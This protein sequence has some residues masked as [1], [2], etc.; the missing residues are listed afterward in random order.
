ML[1]YRND[2]KLRVLDETGN[3]KEVKFKR[4][5]KRNST[6]E[7]KK[8]QR[9]IKVKTIRKTQIPLNSTYSHKPIRPMSKPDSFKT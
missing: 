6:E 4:K 3:R 1:L 8:W 9:K 2:L 7:R 5:R